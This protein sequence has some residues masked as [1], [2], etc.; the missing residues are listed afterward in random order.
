MDTT[1]GLRRADDRSLGAAPVIV[2]PGADN[3]MQRDGLEVR[4][5]LETVRS[6]LAGREVPP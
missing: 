6:C 4:K 3:V 1:E 5:N 2:E